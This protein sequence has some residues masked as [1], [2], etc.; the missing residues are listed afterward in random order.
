MSLAT[1]FF[2]KEAKH[3]CTLL[4]HH[5]Q[6]GTL[7]NVNF[8]QGSNVHNHNVTSAAVRK[9]SAKESE[10]LHRKLD[11]SRHCKKTSWEGENEG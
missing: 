4:Q 6:R 3:T 8:I 7:G 11:R 5:A 1:F 10:L 9:K 2:F